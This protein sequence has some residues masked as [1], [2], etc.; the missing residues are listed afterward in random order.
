MAALFVLMGLGDT[1]KSATIRAL[2]GFARRNPLPLRL[3]ENEDTEIYVIPTSPQEDNSRSFDRGVSRIAQE[4][5]EWDVLLALHPHQASNF[6]RQ[7]PEANR[8]EIHIVPL[9]S[10]GIP[11]DLQQDLS[12]LPSSHLNIYQGI[13]GSANMPV[14]AIAHRIRGE[15][16]WL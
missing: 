12:D 13:P 14:N 16:G 3:V 8:H 5:H 11:T 7:I 15:W 10:E 4:G 2:T 1:R 9:G 6:I